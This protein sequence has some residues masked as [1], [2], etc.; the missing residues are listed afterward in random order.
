MNDSLFVLFTDATRKRLLPGAIPTLNLPPKSFETETK[1]RRPLKRHETYEEWSMF[2]LS[3]SA[4]ISWKNILDVREKEVASM[5][6]QRCKLLVT[7]IC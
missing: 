5:I 3:G 6:I 7:T 1:P 2:C 4:K